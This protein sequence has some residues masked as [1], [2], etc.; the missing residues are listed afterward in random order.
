MSDMHV[1]QKVIISLWYSRVM[2]ILAVADIHGAKN[3][4]NTINQFISKYNPDLVIIDGDITQFGPL[5]YAKKVLDSISIKTLAV[6]GNCDP[7]EILNVIDESKA[8]NLHKN[9]ILINGLTFVGLGGSNI[10]PFN[11]IFEMSEEEIFES[12]DKI[13]ERNAILV[14]H[15]PSKNNMDRVKNV[16]HVGSNAI[17][18]IVEKYQPRL[19]ISAHIHEARGVNYDKIIVIV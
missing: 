19:V 4:V 10:T 15:A 18:Q 14:T 16:G 13:M 6:P 2:L 8:I 12:L 11:T 1:K 5:N 9:K 3:G 7:K 17:A